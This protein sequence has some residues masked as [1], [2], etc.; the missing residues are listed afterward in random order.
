MDL[1][2]NKDLRKKSATQTYDL[3]YRKITGK[4]IPDRDPQRNQLKAFY[5]ECQ[6]LCEIHDDSPLRRALLLAM[7]KVKNVS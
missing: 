6:G 3:L 5:K 1:V 4:Q 7:Q 2:K